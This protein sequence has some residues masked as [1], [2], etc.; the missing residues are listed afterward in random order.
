MERALERVSGHGEVLD[1]QVRDADALVAK[2]R[3]VE[4]AV[5]VLLEHLEAGHVP[6]EA[7]RSPRAEQAHAR[8]RILED[9][10]AEVAEERLDAGADRDEV[11]ARPDLPQLDLADQLLRPDV[12]VLAVGA[13]RDVDVDDAALAHRQ[14]VVLRPT[15]ARILSRPDEAGVPVEHLERQEDRRRPASERD[16][17]RTRRS[18]VAPRSVRWASAASVPRRT[19]PEPPSG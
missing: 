6:L 1:V 14:V 12:I 13:L 15:V 2:V 8:L 10:A 4:A 7:A 11:V 16:R 18:R 9:E 17:R 5:R 3:R 19:C